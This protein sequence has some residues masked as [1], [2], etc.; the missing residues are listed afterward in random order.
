MRSTSIKRSGVAQARRINGT[1]GSETDAPV[2]SARALDF[3]MALVIL[4]AA[5]PACDYRIDR[6]RAGGMGILAFLGTHS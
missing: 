3:A 6:R 2:Q 5:R 1:A 4:R